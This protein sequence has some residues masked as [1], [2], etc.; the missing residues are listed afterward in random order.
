MMI[1]TIIISMMRPPPAVAF[2]S[3]GPGVYL[4]YLILI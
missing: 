4:Y 2:I 3:P 1:I